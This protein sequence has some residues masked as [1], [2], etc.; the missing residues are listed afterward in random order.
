MPNKTLQHII[1]FLLLASFLAVV[2]CSTT[3]R[4]D[5]DEV[6]YIGVDGM[7]ITTADSQRVDDG[8]KANLDEAIDVSPNG[9]II[10]PWLRSPLQF[11]LWIYNWGDSTSTGLKRW[12]VDHLGRT[13][14]L[15]SDVKPDLRL[16]MMRDVLNN[17]GY[18]GSSASYELLYSKDRRQAEILYRVNLTKPYTFSNIEFFHPTTRLENYIDSVAQRQNYLSAGNRYC[19]D[20]LDMV[21]N[22]IT[23]IVRNNGYYFFKPQYIEYLADTTQLHRQMALKLVLADNIPATALKKYYIG[24]VTTNIYNY[25]GVDDN[26]DTIATPRCTLI[27]YN[28]VR[29]RQNAISSAIS[30]RHGR[31]FSVKS[32]ER[33]QSNLS[34][35]GIFSSVD[36]ST[37]P[38]DSITSDTLDVTIDCRLDLPLETKFEIQA[39][40]KSNSYIGPSAVLGL[41]NKNLFGGG[42]QLS[43][44]LKFSYEWQTGKNVGNKLNSYEVGANVNLMFPRLLAPSFVDRSRRYINRT[45]I[46]LS[47]SLI[48]RPKY[49]KMLDASIGMKWEWHATR[50]SLNEFSPLTL[51]YSK[52]LNYS[53][54]FAKMAL[55]NPIIANSFDDK[56]L[57]MMTYSYTYDR[58][59]DSCNSLNWNFSVA[60]SG[61]VICGIWALTGSHGGKDS[62]SLFGTPISQFVKASTQLV[63]SH[64]F[65]PGHWLVG[66]TYLG[67][68][69]AYGNS[70]EVP[71]SEQFYVGGSNSL[72]AFTARSI[73]PGRYHENNNYFEFFDQSGTF[74]FEL[75]L[76]YRFPIIS[77]LHGALF[78]DAGNVWILKEDELRPGAML[79][80]KHFFDDLALGTGAGLRFDAGFIVVRADL[81]IGIHYPYETSKSGYYNMESFKNSLCLHFAIGYPF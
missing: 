61:N 6:L 15:I 71:F 32:I 57:P 65:L 24:N 37:T 7:K 54:D 26:P 41:T 42:E 62:K 72:R 50:Y 12:I 80:A 78:I 60:E 4:I 21:R 40:S 20:S 39:A 33:T 43:T 36:I 38:M 17:N 16:E 9:A 5:P 76:E 14:V 70:S 45:N 63:Y 51:K 23:D 25:Y 11:G 28:P 53:D 13:P 75:N 46:S 48:N 44:E 79:S 69:H 22:R 49:F 10:S 3:R 81:G 1:H 34:R 77:Q 74:K 59:F 19:T 58:R 31:A 47:A 8:L 52:L 27:K 66:R 35:L 30:M 56:F 18:F 55:D 64:Q 2:S 67:I 73:G 68:A 29:V